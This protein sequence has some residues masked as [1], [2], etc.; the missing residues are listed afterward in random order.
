A[1][2]ALHATD[3]HCDN[4]IACGDQPV[5]IDV[6][7]L[8]HPTLPDRDAA[9]TSASESGT[10]GSTTPGST[11]SESTAS[12]S[13]APGSTAADDP[14]ATALAAS[15]RR[16]GLLPYP[17]IGENGLSDQSGLGGDVDGRG[18]DGVLD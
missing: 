1:L 12:G 18:P 14:A 8:L 4:V 5:L 10:S 7:T 6:E 9:A 13:T 15:V 2:Y 17:V 3:M 11:A 16:T